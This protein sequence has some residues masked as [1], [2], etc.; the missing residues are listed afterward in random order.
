MSFYFTL[1]SNSSMSVH[2]ENTLSH[3]YTQL[4]QLVQLEGEWEVGLSE[5][6]F[7]YTWYN[8]PEPLHLLVVPDKSVD[9]NITSHFCSSDYEKICALSITQNQPVPTKVT[10]RPGQYNHRRLID[11]LNNSISNE[12]VSSR[13]RAEYDMIQNRITLNLK[14][15]TTGV[16]MSKEFMEVFGYDTFFL[17]ETQ[18][19]PRCVDLHSR[20]CG[21]YTYCNVVQPRVVGDARVSLLRIIP[22]PLLTQFGQIMTR[23][24]EKVIYFPVG[25]KQFSTL[26]IDI[27]DDTGKCIPFE[28]GKVI[29]TLHFR[30]VKKHLF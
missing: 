19:S 27:R 7:P 2:P 17:G 21:L 1:P 18:R 8:V 6:Q 14:F 29:V 25:T 11:A 20:H 4:P 5:I 13:V 16:Y 12:R 3:Y 23:I 10:L 9:Y 26:E 24:Y 15:K 28:N 22:M 30:R